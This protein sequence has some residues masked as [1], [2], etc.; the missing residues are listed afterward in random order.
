MKKYREELSNESREE[1]EGILENIPG[2]IPREIHIEISGGINEGPSGGIFN[3]IPVRICFHISGR[4]PK[5]IHA[6][7]LEE[8][9][10]GISGETP[11][12]HGW[13]LENNS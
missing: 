10:G 5:K 6:G 13:N 9:P 3:A 12:S 8:I 2:G 7:S 4:M 11:G 1:S